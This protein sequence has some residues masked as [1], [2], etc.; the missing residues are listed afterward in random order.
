MSPPTLLG[1]TNTMAEEAIKT[2]DGAAEEAGAETKVDVNASGEEAGRE[3]EESGGGAGNGGTTT[4][5]EKIDPAVRKQPEDYIRERRS[6]REQG[7]GTHSG[8][9]EEELSEPARRYLD[10]RVEEIVG[11]RLKPLEEKIT[12]TS[13]ESEM[14]R[15]V[16]SL[17]QDRF[18]KFVPLARKAMDAWKGITAED[19]LLWAESKYGNP[20]ERGAT[21]ERKRQ[22]QGSRTRSSGSSPRP[23]SRG[24]NADITANEI[25]AM[26]PEQFT[27]FNEGLKGGKQ[28]KTE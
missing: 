3:G 9:E 8:G 22:A 14:G 13:V 7:D 15:A 5:F 2:A 19:A 1:E 25:A 16:S 23:P 10:K 17:G 20:A 12:D 18:S 21:E 26:T 28:L 6:G 24:G 27:Q 11:A 4:D